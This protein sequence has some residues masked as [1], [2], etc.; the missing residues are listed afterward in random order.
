MAS[1]VQQDQRRR[2]IGL[3][4]DAQNVANFDV[5]R[6]GGDRTLLRFEDLERDLGAVRQQGAAPAPRPEDA[7]RRQR[8]QPRPPGQDRAAGGEIVGGGPRRGRHQ[9]AVG[10][11]LG[12]PYVAV[13]QNL[14]LGRLVFLPPQRH[15][16]DRSRRLLLAVHIARAHEQRMDDRG[17]RRRQAGA[18]APLGK[19]VHQE[20]ERAAIHPV[21]RLR[22]RHGAVQGLQHR[23]VP[24]QGDDD[25]GLF[26]GDVA[27]AGDEPLARPLGFRR[28]GSDEID[29]LI[30]VL[31]GRLHVHAGP[32]LREGAIEERRAGVNS[33]LAAAKGR[34]GPGLRRKSGPTP[35]RGRA[36]SPGRGSAG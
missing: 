32:S 10:D 34:P 1:V 30:F 26:I 31:Y 19:V 17:L 36:G 6:R 16:I 13:D 12:Q 9:H 23:A 29:R 18:Q 14:D 28:E 22:R 11:Q 3:D 21:Y 20:A 2:V 8:H 4:V 15:F 25:V 24:A 27:V 35:A 5:V 33:R 7:D